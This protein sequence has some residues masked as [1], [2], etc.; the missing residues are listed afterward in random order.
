MRSNHTSQLVPRL[1]EVNIVGSKWVYRTK[2]L[3]DDIVD[4]LKARLVPQGFS[5]LPS[6]DYAHTFSH[7]LKTTMVR[8]ILTLAVQRNWP[9]HQLDVKNVF[10]NGF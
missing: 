2:Y 5:Q 9:L 1:I 6:L 7:V 8:T 10:L 4:R 3:Y